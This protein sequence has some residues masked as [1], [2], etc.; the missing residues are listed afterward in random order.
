MIPL[1][2]SSLEEIHK[3][4]SRYSVR[5]LE[6]FGSAA[7]SE[8]DPDDIDFVVEFEP[9][10]PIPHAEAYFGL[11]AALM[12]LLGKEIDLLEA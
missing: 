11:R 9:L 7:R 3:L 1:I 12:R 8:G 4:C 6:L 2:G 10:A 5:S